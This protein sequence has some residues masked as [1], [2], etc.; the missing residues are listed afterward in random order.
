MPSPA[1]NPVNL[2]WNQDGCLTND[3]DATYSWTADSRLVAVTPTGPAAAS[4]PRLEFV[5]D[6]QGRR[7][8]RTVI[9]ANAPALSTTT[10]FI[11]DGYDTDGNV[12]VLSPD[13]AVLGGPEAAISPATPLFTGRA[14]SGK[15]R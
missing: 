2:A 4:R 6:P 15:P 1:P 13:G 5:Y 10:Y 11:W 3:A 9:P 14:V 12:T 8:A 7:L